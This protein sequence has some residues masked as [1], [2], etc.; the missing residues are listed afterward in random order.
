MES[1]GG[2]DGSSVDVGRGCGVGVVVASRDEC[3]AAAFGV[4][5]WR[6]RSPGF[7]PPFEARGGS[8]L[9]GVALGTTRGSGRG[10]D[11]VSGAT[12]GSVVTVALRW[13]DDVAGR[14]RV[15]AG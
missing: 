9:N 4:M 5:A 12:S 10:E 6:S 8:N 1:G 11:A 2:S 13:T 15:S 14:Q 7:Q 3:P